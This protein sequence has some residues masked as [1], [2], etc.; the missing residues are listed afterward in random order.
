M[1]NIIEALNWRYATKVF[2]KDKKVGEEDLAELL[3]ALRLTPSSFGLQP[4]KFI[5]VNDPAVR[6][7]L[8]AVA[9]D[10]SGVTDASHFIVFTS[11][12][13]LDEKYVDRFLG[14]NSEITGTPVEKLAS[15]KQM[16]MGFAAAMDERGKEEWLARQT[17]IALGELLTICALKEIDACPMEG[18]DPKK[19]DEILGLTG[20]PYAVHIACAIGYRSAEDKYAL[21]KKV[22][23][24]KNE[25]ISEI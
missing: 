8:R 17:Y 13:T 10:Q 18:F 16:V 21:A 12:H 24:N 23:F 7:K 14:V 3:E 15:Y 1:Q 20:T 19:F 6:A 22:R 11:L 9:W 25:I 4:W 5:I 2:D